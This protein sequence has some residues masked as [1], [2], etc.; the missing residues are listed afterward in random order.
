M[1]DLA[2][3]QMILNRVVSNP[4]WEDP[5]THRLPGISPLDMADWLWVLDSYPAQMAERERLLAE[6]TPRVHALPEA[7]LPAAQELYDIVLAQLADRGDF[8]LEG[9]VMR[10]P[11][12]RLV[13]LDR[14]AP[15][16]TLGRLVQEDLCL[17]E[18]PPGGTE[19]LLTAAVLCF[20]AS[21]TLSEKLGRPMVAIHR[22]VA[23]Y[24]AE[25]ARRVQRLL[26]GVR[27]G[28]PL[29]R[30]NRHHYR[31]AALFHPL[32]EGEV[33]AEAEN[34]APFLRSERQCLLRL[35]ETGAVAFS[36]HT[37]VMRR[38][39]LPTGAAVAH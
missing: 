11:D 7:A 4:P 5:R 23:E 1:S 24:D 34:E 12:S 21:W 9:E 35:P 33:R 10:C 19:H 13:R 26:D 31:D 36:I 8:R 27:P 22:P 20:P 14:D 32:R 15:L 29:W 30:A 39:D 37:M 3:P 18:K 16:L 28:R 6:V 17:L 25:L 38:S 2:Q